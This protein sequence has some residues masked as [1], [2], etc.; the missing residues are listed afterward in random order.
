[1]SGET[2]SISQAYGCGFLEPSRE[3]VGPKYLDEL[4]T[5]EYLGNGG[6]AIGLFNLSLRFVTSG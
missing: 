5:M 6:N 1:M 2:I 4:D 3:H